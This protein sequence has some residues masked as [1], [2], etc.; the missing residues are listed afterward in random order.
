MFFKKTKRVQQIHEIVDA[1][2]SQINASENPEAASVIKL[3]KADLDDKKQAAP[4]V[5][6]K[7]ANALYQQ[8]LAHEPDLPETVKPL[9]GELK[10]LISA[11]GYGMVMGNVPFWTSRY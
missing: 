11:N 9:L 7:L 1:M 6:N 3:A 10:N 8:K 4:V 5:A 2:A